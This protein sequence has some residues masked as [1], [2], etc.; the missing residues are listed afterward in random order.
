M[1]DTLAESAIVQDTT[2]PEIPAIVE[3]D[4]DADER[5]RLK[6]RRQSSQH[7]PRRASSP[8]RGHDRNSGSR[9]R[10]HYRKHHR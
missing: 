10:T 1:A 4:V 7:S 3:P 5:G 6:R 9:Y 8:S 2:L